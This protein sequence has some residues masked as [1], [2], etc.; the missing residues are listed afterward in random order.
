MVENADHMISRFRAKFSAAAVKKHLNLPFSSNHLCFYPGYLPHPILGLEVVWKLP[1][2]EMKPEI[3]TI[4]KYD[5]S[6]SF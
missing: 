4:V 6:L 3:V 5:T 2:L 1:F